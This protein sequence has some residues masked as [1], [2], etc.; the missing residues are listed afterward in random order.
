MDTS[1]QRFLWSLGLSADV[2]IHRLT[3]SISGDL[4]ALLI[5]ELLA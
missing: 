1:K 4:Y 5:G 2:N 3:I